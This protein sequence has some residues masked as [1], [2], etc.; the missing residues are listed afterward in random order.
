LLALLHVAKPQRQCFQMIAHSFT[1][2][3]GGGGSV[4]Q[5]KTLVGAAEDPFFRGGLATQNARVFAAGRPAG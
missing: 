2:T 1:K 3:A 5:K 4:G